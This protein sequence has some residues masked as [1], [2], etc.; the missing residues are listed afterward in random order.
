MLES[1]LE[2]CDLLDRLG[3]T[4]YCVSLKDSDPARVVDVNRRF[5][6]ERPEVPLHLGVTEAGMPPEGILKTRAALDAASFAGDR[7]YNSRFAHRARRA[8]A[9][10]SRSRVGKSWPTWPPVAC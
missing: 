9:R 5:A 7:R 3:F 4:R 10:G 2:H 1:A 8:Q 6:A